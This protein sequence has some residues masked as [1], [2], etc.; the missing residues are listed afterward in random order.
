MFEVLVL[1]PKA[2]NDGAV[3]TPAHD[4]AFE[5]FVLDRIGGLTWRGNAEGVWASDG[6][7]YRDSMRTLILAVRSIADG[8]KVSEVALFAKKHY[9]QEAIYIS[10]LGLAEII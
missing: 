5:S 8:G 4:L 9:V 6:R 10:F 3:F 7:I 2:D 1:I